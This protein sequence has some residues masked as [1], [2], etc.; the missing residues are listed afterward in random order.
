LV[1]LYDGNW[2][3]NADLMRMGFV[4]GVRAMILLSGSH[5]IADAYAI[6]QH[7]LAII[8]VDRQLA[9]ID[10][11]GVSAAD[12]LRTSGAIGGGGG[13]T[14]IQ[15]ATIAALKA[16]R[17][18]HVDA[19][20]ERVKLT[21]DE[22][23]AEAGDQDVLGIDQAV[24]G[25]VAEVLGGDGSTERTVGGTQGKLINAIARADPTEQMAAELRKLEE[26]G[27][28]TTEVMGD[29]FRNLRQQADVEATRLYPN[30]TPDEL[31]EHTRKL[32]DQWF[33]HLQSTWNASVVGTG[34][35]FSQLLDRGDQSEV[36][37]K[38][39]LYMASGKL[40]DVDEL[41]LALRGGRKDLET[42][43]RVLR[44]KSRDEIDE[45]KRLYKIKTTTP[46][47]KWGGSLDEDL[48]G[49]APS[50]AGQKD[51][52]ESDDPKGKAQGTDRLLI[53]DFLQRPYQEGGK[54]EVDYIVGRA[55]R[56]QEYTIANRG[57]TGWWRDHWGNEARSLLDAT[58]KEVRE[59]RD[60]YL[61]LTKNG[62]DRAAMRGR[63]AKL[64]IRDM[65]FARATIRGDRAGYEKAT[66][67]L[68]ATFQA[69]A[70]FVLQAVLTAVLTPAAAALFRGISAAAAAT[71]YGIWLKNTVVSLSST[72]AANKAVYGNE[73]TRE[74]L[75]AD[76]RGGLSGAIGSAAV[77]KL[78]D[79]IAGRLQSRLGQKMSGEFIEGVKSYGGLQATAVLGGDGLVSFDEFAKQH[80][81]GKVG[82]RITGVTAKGL[83]HV[84][85]GPGPTHAPYDPDAPTR[86]GTGTATHG[87]GSA[88]QETEPGRR[89][90]PK[91]DGDVDVEDALTPT[92]MTLPPELNK[93]APRAPGSA[94]RQPSGKEHSLGPEDPP[95]ATDTDPVHEPADSDVDTNATKIAP[96]SD[97][98]IL[99]DAEM[100]RRAEQ[101]PL[102]T[103]SLRSSTA[104]TAQTRALATEFAPLFEKF[105][106]MTDVVPRNHAIAE[107]IRRNLAA[108]GVYEIVVLPTDLGG[109]GSHA[110]FDVIHWE[111]NI[112]SR[113]LA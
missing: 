49:F 101:H 102:D 110:D 58:L 74:M 112:D 60:Q 12:V 76:L 94:G 90:G 73:Y 61:A 83:G 33:I 65:H 78:V 26:R 9:E 54:E 87:S 103:K 27:Q 111:I 104:P 63:D 5:T 6:R 25:R 80:F 50:R 67:E 81:L 32:S 72:I 52:T 8:E 59:K 86:A 79:P 39:T 41:V 108:E 89:S 98:K 1:R 29:M 48:I 47:N 3:L 10:P 40:A 55:E 15:K 11:P 30:D 109:K 106:T 100:A 35:T 75:F 46:A 34:R 64:L 99:H 31:A 28:L 24:R 45:L 88:G 37:Y 92:S 66:A 44:N 38:R 91:P 17:K 113:A 23:R 71:R 20:E 53:E 85:Y 69:I 77:G 56:E 42:V 14:A 43:K 93:P 19:I 57:A 13:L 70:S 18:T 95:K 97:R 68:R 105:K 16:Q 51:T 7:R 2:S 22:A 36:D 21:A 62:T 96:E 82:E 107:I 84:G 4:N